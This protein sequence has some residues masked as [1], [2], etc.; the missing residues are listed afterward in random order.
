MQTSDFDPEELYNTPISTDDAASMYRRKIQKNDR[1]YVA[2]T[3]KLNNRKVDD[4]KKKVL[5]KI[6]NDGGKVPVGR[7]EK[8]WRLYEEGKAIEKYIEIKNKGMFPTYSEE[9]VE[10]WKDFFENLT[11]EE[12]HEYGSGVVSSGWSIIMDYIKKWYAD[13][14]WERLFSQSSEPLFWEKNYHPHTDYLDGKIMP[15][16]DQD[17]FQDINQKVASV[18]GNEVKVVAATGF[19]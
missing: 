5:Q 4:W 16:W 13:Q 3:T 17:K 12:L 9:M 7:V 10:F 14:K 2:E 1:P 19:R 15:L 8:S 6:C 18:L 11:V